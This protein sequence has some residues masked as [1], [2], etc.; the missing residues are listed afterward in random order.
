MNNVKV[1]LITHTVVSVGC[2]LLLE[3]IGFG[4]ARLLRLA[5]VVGLVEFIVIN[6]ASAS[7]PVLTDHR[8]TPHAI[9]GEWNNGAKEAAITMANIRQ[10]N[11]LSIAL[12]SR[13]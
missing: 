8:S 7:V 9:A 11:F 12:L 3:G 13:H 1:A 10:D 5:I 2:T 6:P 4:A